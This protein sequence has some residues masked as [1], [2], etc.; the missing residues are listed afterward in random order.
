MPEGDVSL[1]SFECND[2]TY[3]EQPTW[4]TRS[5]R[6]TRG[7]ELLYGILYQM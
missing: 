2:F 3:W 4:E 6:V 1:S 5:Q 7:R